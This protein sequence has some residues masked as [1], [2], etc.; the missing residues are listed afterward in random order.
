MEMRSI[1]EKQRQS[2]NRLSFTLK[3][4]RPFANYSLMMAAETSGGLGPYSKPVFCLTQ[5]MPPPPAAVKVTPS[6]TDKNTVIISWLLPT[7]AAATAKKVV[8]FNL[9]RSY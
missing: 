6:S 8:G 1:V 9:Y 3:N 7:A 5:Q 4:L 2:E